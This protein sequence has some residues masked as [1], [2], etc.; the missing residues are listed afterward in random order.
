M[1]GV[2]SNG[3]NRT[4]SHLVTTHEKYLDKKKKR[5]NLIKFFIIYF[6]MC[7]QI[8]FIL[9]DQAHG[10]GSGPFLLVFILKKFFLTDLSEIE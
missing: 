1:C 5:K 6:C 7:F 3:L 2:D 10:D 8:F 4:W 9:V